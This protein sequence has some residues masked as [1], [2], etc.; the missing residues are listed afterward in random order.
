M[1]VQGNLKHQNVII[2]KYEHR[3]CIL[4]ESCQNILS[5]VKLKFLVTFGHIKNKIVI[6]GLDVRSLHQFILALNVINCVC[7]CLEAILL[8]LLIFDKIMILYDKTNAK[9][10]YNKETL[11]VPNYLGIVISCM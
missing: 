9:I 10:H 6:F 11:E 7:Y 1:F 5:L 2:I 8:D 4:Q 3:K